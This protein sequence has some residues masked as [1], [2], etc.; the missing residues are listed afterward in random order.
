[1]PE[2]KRL[3][4][5][6]DI[7]PDALSNAQIGLANSAASVVTSA[8]STSSTTAYSTVA[9]ISFTPNKTGKVLVIGRMAVYN[10]TAGDGVS[11]ELLNGST[12]IDGPFTLLSS[13]ASQ[14]QV[15][16]LISLQTGLTVGTAYTFSTA[17]EAVTGGTAYGTSTIVA[18]ELL[19]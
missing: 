16:T 3:I 4:N 14:V 13:A 11:V 19:A 9:S 6:A 5:G 12:A 18:M 8:V 10:N 15:A 2:I 1:M 17:I 7:V